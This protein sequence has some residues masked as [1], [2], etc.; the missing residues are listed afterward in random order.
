MPTRW[1]TT[2][3]HRRAENAGAAAHRGVAYPG[4]WVAG[5][6]AVFGPLLI[7]TGV[8]LRIR[9][10]FFFPDQL[11]AY[12][13]QP[14]LITASY[15]CFASGTV[16]L[17]PAVLA[18]AHRIGATHPGWALWGGCLVMFG[19]FTR[20]FHFGTDHLA[21]HLVDSQGVP[22]AV[23]AVDHYYLAWRDVGWHPFRM[24]A[25]TIVAGWVVLAIGAYRS[26]ALGPLRAVSLGTVSMLALGTL[27]GTQIPQSLI[28]A[29]ALCV[30]FVPLGV[31][32]LRDGPRP[33]NR[34]LFWIAVLIPLFVLGQFYAPR[35]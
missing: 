15:A 34:A 18:L 14:G 30:V 8:L 7:L 3:A 4:R 11:A 9:Y 32:V 23:A 31:A 19:L 25:G 35:G 13:K 28:A 33:S 5:L 21:F 1:R 20:T 10:H 2:I 24:L 26:G 22:A 6:A 16:L 12:E 27:K 29:A 17:W